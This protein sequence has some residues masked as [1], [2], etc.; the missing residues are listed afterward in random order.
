M[1]AVINDIGV[2]DSHEMG[3]VLTRHGQVDGCYS[4]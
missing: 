4:V 1:A 3:I 2:V